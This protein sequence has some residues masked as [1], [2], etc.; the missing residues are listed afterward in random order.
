MCRNIITVE[1]FIEMLVVGLRARNVQALQIRWQIYNAILII[2]IIKHAH[3]NQV[4]IVPFISS[5]ENMA[6]I[7]LHGQFGKCVCLSDSITAIMS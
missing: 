6:C 4:F 7:C 3:A 5:D 1:N 2:I